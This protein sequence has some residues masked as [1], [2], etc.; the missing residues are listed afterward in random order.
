MRGFFCEKEKCGQKKIP[1]ERRGGSHF[2]GSTFNL[3]GGGSSMCAGR[4]LSYC[5]GFLAYFVL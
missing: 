2:H 5:D 3:R 1:E 4:L